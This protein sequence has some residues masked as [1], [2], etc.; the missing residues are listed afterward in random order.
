MELSSEEIKHW[1]DLNLLKVQ[2]PG[3]YVG[4]ELNQVK[5]SWDL[6]KIHVALAFPDI[7]EIGISNLGLMILYDIVNRLDF[8]LAERVY[9]PWMD[10]E[11]LMR[12]AQIP[13]F[14]LESKM[15]VG[16]FDIIGISLPYE[17]LY[18]NAINLLDLSKLP[19]R[20]IERSQNQPLII[21]GGHAVSNPEPLADFID[22]FVIGD[23]E[24]I[25]VDICSTW[26]SWKVMKGSKIDLLQDLSKIEGIYV[27]RFYTPHYLS[28]GLMEAIHPS[29]DSI[30]K[31]VL[32]TMWNL[33]SPLPP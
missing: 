25:I 28:T 7:Y 26:L 19:V 14:S 32:Q 22:A 29:Q 4:G 21:A 3:R 9:S 5:K 23:G 17:T 2:K 33:T 1:L 13:L 27:P 6:M 16:A 18:T 20:S 12:Q 15:P 31:Q 10:M 30:P 11:S 24:G 8:A